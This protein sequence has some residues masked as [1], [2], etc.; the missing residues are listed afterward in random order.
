MPTTPVHQKADIITRSEGAALK[1]VGILLIVTHNLAHCLGSTGYDCNEYKFDHESA[2]ALFRF[3]LHPG[4]SI[5]IQLS[6]LL[7]YCGIY[8]F[9]F[10]S[11]FGLVRKY[12]QGST[13]MPAPHIF[14]WHHYTKLFKLMFFALL[15]A[16]LA[17]WLVNS[18]NQP[19]IGDCVAQMLMITNWLKPPYSH[20]FP[21][22]Y[23][24]FGL[25]M[26]LYV[27]YRLVLYVPRGGAAW[28]KWLLPLVFVVVTV[29][30]QIWLRNV[31]REMIYMR[32]NF[33]T[34][35]LTFSAGL[36]VARYGG[37][38]RMKKWAWAGVF[39]V[40]TVVFI[41]MQKSPVMWI[42][43][44]LVVTVAMIA[45][46]K[47]F[48]PTVMRPIVWVGGIS[49]FLFVVHPAV[50]TFALH[51]QSGIINHALILIYTIVAIIVA[52]AYRRFLIAIGWK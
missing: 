13:Q 19:S 12:E 29:A 11:A 39:A 42:L 18:P 43:S 23:W 6:T 2:D 8:A 41:L 32:Y 21:G 46:V 34:T 37:I 10:M 35:G 3:I 28:R 30:P 24:F 52:V 50:R 16:I 33:F 9:L 4:Q 44:S 49:S 51:F 17:V 26:E 45:L 7:G 15:A 40:A 36:L 48:S 38:P 31:G 27:I 25:M 5:L 1:G 14:V 47:T 20:V 22:P